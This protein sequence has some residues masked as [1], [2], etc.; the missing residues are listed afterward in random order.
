MGELLRETEPSSSRS[1]DGKFKEGSVLPEGISWNQSSQ[2][3][4]MAVHKGIVEQVKVLAR[5]RDD[6]LTGFDGVVMK[7]DKAWKAE[8]RTVGKLFNSS[9]QLMKG[10]NEKADIIHPL[11]EIDCKLRQRW[12]VDRDFRALQKAADLKGKI[13]VLTLRQ[14]SKRL[15][16]AVVTLDTLISLVKG[17]GWLTDG[18]T[19]ATG[20]RSR[21]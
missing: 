15:R 14:P 16:L 20:G 5:E 1:E 9:R 13:P 21:R 6:L 10:T 17:A 3:Q 18:D 2:F 4:K 11:F 12:N 19:E 7:L 8:E